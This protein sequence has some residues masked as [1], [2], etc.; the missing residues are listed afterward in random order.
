MAN[1]LLKHLYTAELNSINFVI[2][3]FVAEWLRSSEYMNMRQYETLSDIETF[4]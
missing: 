3:S 1:S 4:V 2:S